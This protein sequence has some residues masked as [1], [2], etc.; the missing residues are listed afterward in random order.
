MKVKAVSSMIAMSG[1]DCSV[2]GVTMSIFRDGAYVGELEITLG[3]KL[4]K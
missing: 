4:L 2:S 1:G 3:R